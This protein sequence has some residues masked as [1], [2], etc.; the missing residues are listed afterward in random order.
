MSGQTSVPN[1]RETLFE[2]PDLTTIYGEPTYESLR[3][4]QNQLKANVCSIRTT[5]GGGHQELRETSNLQVRETSFNSANL[6]QEVID[7]VQHALQVSEPQVSST[8]GVINHLANNAAQQ[9]L[10]PQLM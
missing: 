1:Y 9:Q 7:D 6:V 4:I 2:Y 8:P 10:M 3:I 5:L